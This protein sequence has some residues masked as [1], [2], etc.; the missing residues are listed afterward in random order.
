MLRSHILIGGKWLGIEPAFTWSC[1]WVE[2]AAAGV[3]EG[4]IAASEVVADSPGSAHMAAADTGST[5]MSAIVSRSAD[6][7]PSV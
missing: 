5:D 3:D 1:V 2:A 4:S 7:A 6:V